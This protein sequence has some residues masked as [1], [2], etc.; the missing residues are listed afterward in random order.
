[1]I[2]GLVLSNQFLS[3]KVKMYRKDKYPM[4]GITSTFGKAYIYI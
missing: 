2:K 4:Q 1:M 3:T